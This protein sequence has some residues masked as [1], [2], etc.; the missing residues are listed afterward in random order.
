METDVRE[1][2]T[3][4]RKGMTGASLGPIRS[5]LQD[6]KNRKEYLS[7]PYFRIPNNRKE[8]FSKHCFSIPN[9]RK[10]YL[11]MCVYICR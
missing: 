1:I 7:D 9:N 10:E 3:C 11:Y 5:L 2:D 4:T 6:P 8:H